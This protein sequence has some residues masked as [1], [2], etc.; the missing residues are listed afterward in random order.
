M[1][2]RRCKSLM[3]E[4]SSSFS[5]DLPN[6]I[7][8]GSGVVRKSQWLAYAGHLSEPVALSRPDL[9]IIEEISEIDYIDS[10]E[11]YRVYNKEAIDGLIMSGLL[12]TEDS[13][14]DA[15]SR[16]I[17]WYPLAEIYYV[18]GRWDNVSLN[19]SMDE[20]NKSELEFI[21]PSNTTPP[22]Y[23]YEHN[24]SQ[25]RIALDT[26]KPVE[27]DE[28]LDNRNTCRSFDKEKA[29]SIHALSKIFH[30]VFRARKKYT[31]ESGLDIV[32]KTSPAGGGIH[33]TEAYLIIRRVNGINPGVYHYLPTT[34]TLEMLCEHSL[35]YI[36][37]CVEKVLAG[38]SWFEGAAVYIVMTARFE[39]LFWKYRNH[40]K[41]YRVCNLDA[42]HAS[43]TLYLSATDMGLG[44]FVSAAVNDK[45]TEE[46]LSINPLK[47]GVL[48]VCGFGPKNEDSNHE[49]CEANN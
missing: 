15:M 44:A 41:A 7:D 10:T 46:I 45:Q 16:L 34:H 24:R 8:G 21:S 32:H 29:I 2:V 13:K 5:L 38:Q 9:Q 35:D 11:L 3:F 17:P 25:T 18:Y 33:A 30:R 22:A 49:S 27:L 6:L 1:R 36:D 19:S 26:P 37:E 47:E 40:S 20:S 31:L 43:Q 39:R 48:A 12:V 42:G 4:L 14:S 28:V 23:L